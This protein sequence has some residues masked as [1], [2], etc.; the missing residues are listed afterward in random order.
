VT[1]QDG[2]EPLSIAVLASGSGSNLEAILE[3]C[4]TG[5]VAARVVAVVANVPDAF[6]LERARR[7]GVPAFVANHRDH[8][9]RRD[10]ERRILE[11]LAPHGPRLLVLAGYMRVVTPTLIDAFAGRIRPGLPG[12]MNIHPAD[13]RVYQGAHGYE[14]A[15]GL[16]PGAPDRLTETAITVHFVDAGIDT[17]PVI[18]RRPVPVLPDD[19]LD[20]LRRRGLAV[21]HALYPECVDLVARGAVSVDGGVVRVAGE[22]VAVTPLAA[23]R[24]D[25]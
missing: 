20:A 18:A 21:E 12:V 10:H 23:R 22:P 2:C 13:T 3:A 4:R 5:R 16:L 15:L 24:G 19:D 25:A 7:C 11:L 17:G 14:R 6:A 9:S 8:A 1:A